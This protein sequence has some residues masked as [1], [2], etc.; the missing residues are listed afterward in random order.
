LCILQFNLF[1][2]LPYTFTITRQLNINLYFSLTFFFV[3]FLLGWFKKYEIILAH[4]TPL[5]S[6]NILAPFLVFIEL[7]RTLI[8]PLTLS[9][10]LTANIISGHILIEIFLRPLENI[11]IRLKFI[12]YIFIL[13][14]FFLEVVVCFVQAF[15]ISSLRRLYLREPLKH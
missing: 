4:I 8:R 3:F 12:F 10:R 11:V 6:P 7:I 13:P 5:G 9:V 14:I 1:G 2:L 15:V